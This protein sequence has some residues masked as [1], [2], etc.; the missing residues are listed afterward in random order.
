MANEGYWDSGSAFFLARVPRAKLRALKR[1]DYQFYI[2]GNGTLDSS[3]TSTQTRARPVISNKGK[4]GEPSVQ[5]IPALNRYLL[6]TFSYPEGLAIAN[7][8]SEHTLWSAYEAPRPWGPWTLINSTEW[9]K[10][11]YYNPIILNDTAYSGT[12]PTIMFTGDFFGVGTFQMYTAT[13]TIL[14]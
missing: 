10:L 8:H 13:M 7:R 11:G 4:L 6:L 1:S 2:G 14:H 12:S 3:W 9:Q 5:F